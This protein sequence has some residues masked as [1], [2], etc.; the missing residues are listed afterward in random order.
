MLLGLVVVAASASAC[1]D[2]RMTT[3]EIMTLTRGD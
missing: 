2:L 3:D 1:R